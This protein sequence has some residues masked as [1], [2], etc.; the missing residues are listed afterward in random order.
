MSAVAMYKDLIDALGSDI[1]HV[2]R[3]HCICVR[4]SSGPDNHLPADEQ[5]EV[6]DE[7]NKAMKAIMAEKLSSSIRSIKTDS[8]L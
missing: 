5:I 2:S 8:Y 4:H 7:I 3:L 6:C 1:M